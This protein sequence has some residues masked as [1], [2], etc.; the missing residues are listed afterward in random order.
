MHIDGNIALVAHTIVVGASPDKPVEGRAADVILAAYNALQGAYRLLKPGK[1]NS[2]VTSLIAKV[3]ESYKCNPLEGVLSHELKKH[4]I[5]GNSC[6]INKETFEQKVEEREFQV[7][8]VYG[9][10][11]IVSTGE[12]KSKEVI[13]LFLFKFLLKNIYHL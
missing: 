4:L 9:L 2:E 13:F 7:G 3:A 6:I 5:D 11:V 8:E 1:L 10:D 12:G